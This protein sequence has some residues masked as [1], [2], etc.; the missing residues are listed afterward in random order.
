[1]KSFYK[2]VRKKTLQVEATKV[3][4]KLP[5]LQEQEVN[6]CGLK[7]KIQILRKSV[8]SLKYVVP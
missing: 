6:G 4:V 5:Q 2:E 3:I 8:D 1:M 7:G